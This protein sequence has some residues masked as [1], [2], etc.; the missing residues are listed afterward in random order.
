M[1]KNRHDFKNLDLYSTYEIKGLNFGALLNALKNRG[2]TVYDVRKTGEKTHTVTVNFAQNRNFFAIAK[3]LCYTDIRKIKDGGKAYPVLFF[4][5]NLGLLVGAALFLV[6]AFFSS[7]FIF[8]FSF[9]GS[10]SVLK[11]EMENYLKEKGVTQF[12]RF[13][14]IDLTSLSD[15]LL[16]DNPRLSFVECQRSGNILVIESALSEEGGKVLSGNSERLVSDVAGTV[17]D[18]KI[19]RGT[20]LV[21]EGD[22]V[23]AGDVLVDGTVVVKDVPV[24]VGVIAYVTV[25]AEQIFTYVS[26]N[27]GEETLAIIFAEEQ[28]GEK[29]AEARVEKTCEQG[30]F[31]Y[32]VT[33]VFSRVLFAG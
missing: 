14:D 22:R 17:T 16:A 3:E 29:D 27:D 32:T 21:K 28:T 25:S 33:L 20:A 11:R 6:L 13:S 19:Y 26:D 15:G 4:F 10:G 5:R 18:I 9:S 2:I 23:A 8:S 12:S 1:R 7:D 30:R 31:V 24:N